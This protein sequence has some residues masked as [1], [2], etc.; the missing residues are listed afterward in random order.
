MY[1]E[2]SCVLT[3]GKRVIDDDVQYAAL[4]AQTR[5]DGVGRDAGV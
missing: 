1:K 3:S 2:H 4:L 5:A